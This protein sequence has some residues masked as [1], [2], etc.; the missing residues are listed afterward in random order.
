MKAYECSKHGEHWTMSKL[1]GDCPYC[2]AEKAEAAYQTLVA[3]R[4]NDKAEVEQ[5]KKTLSIILDISRYPTGH[6]QSEFTKIWKLTN[7]AIGE[8]E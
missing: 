6:H 2:R 1:L 5:L 7:D 8:G 3:L 4:A